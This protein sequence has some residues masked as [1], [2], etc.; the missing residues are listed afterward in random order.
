[1]AAPRGTDKGLLTHVRLLLL[2]TTSKCRSPRWG[3]FGECVRVLRN[4]SRRLSLDWRFA[5]C[6]SSGPIVVV[7]KRVPILDLRL[8]KA[9]AA[10]ASD[11]TSDDSARKDDYLTK[12]VIP[13]PICLM[14][15]R[16]VEKQMKM[17]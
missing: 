16:Q 7:T 5:V 17:R 12:A 10:I 13:A 9:F 3:I 4:F 11:L 15:K 2:G 8:K 1:V 14:I 6:I